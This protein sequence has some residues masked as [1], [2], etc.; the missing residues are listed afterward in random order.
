MD[1]QPGNLAP[2]PCISGKCI[3]ARGMGVQPGNLAPAFA[4]ELQVIGNTYKSEHKDGE[5][6]E[7]RFSHSPHQVFNYIR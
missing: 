2:A 1:V 7:S 6:E 3:N 4:M 5:C